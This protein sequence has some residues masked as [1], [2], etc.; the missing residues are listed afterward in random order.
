M[1]TNSFNINWPWG[2]KTNGLTWRWIISPN[3]VAKTFIADSRFRFDFGVEFNENFTHND[4][5]Q[6]DDIDVDS[7]YIDISNF[8]I[9]F[10]DKI[11]DQ[12][13]ETEFAWLL[14]KNHKIIKIYDKVKPAEHS[15]EVLEFIRNN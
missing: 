13:V 4:T 10:F 5:L 1:I 3:I 7:T 15:Q 2:N 6:I 8:G 9:N 14:N 12:S 11:N